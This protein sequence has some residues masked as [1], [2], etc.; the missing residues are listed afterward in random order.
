MKK[1]EEVST[2]N[3]FKTPVLK[4]SMKNYAL[5]DCRLA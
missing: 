4:P 3:V 1:I 2:Q 5:V